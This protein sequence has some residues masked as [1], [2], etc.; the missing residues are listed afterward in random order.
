VLTI[1]ARCRFLLTGVAAA[2]ASALLATPALAAKAPAPVAASGCPDKAVFQP[3]APWGDDADYFLIPGGAIDHGAPEWTL[4]GGATEVKG[5]EPFHVVS[6]KHKRS[7]ALPAGSSATSAPF[8][9]SAEHRTMR[10]FADAASSSSLDVDVL[11]ADAQGVRRSMRIGQLGGG[12][13]WAPTAIVPMV[14]NE[15]A[16]TSGAMSVR[17]RF[18]PRGAGAWTIDDVLVDPYRTR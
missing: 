12:D 9:I 4:H 15:Q 1:A 17:L 5:N 18:A 7:L 16:A 8:C 10:F 13:A 14:V 2:T 6:A 11:Y 3:F